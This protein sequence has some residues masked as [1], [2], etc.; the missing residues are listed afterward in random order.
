MSGNWGNLS[1]TVVPLPSS[2]SIVKTPRPHD[3]ITLY[4]WTNPN[5]RSQL[6]LKVISM[7]SLVDIYILDP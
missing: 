2:D 4:V 7:G 5:T 3:A 1:R 6:P